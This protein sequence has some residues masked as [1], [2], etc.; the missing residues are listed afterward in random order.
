MQTI[1][2]ILD[3]LGIDSVDEMEINE[4]HTVDGGAGFMDLTIEKVGECRLLV[5]HYYEQN[6]DIMADPEIRFR[7]EDSEWIPYEYRHDPY[8]HQLDYDGEVDVRSFIT[9][10]N[11]NLENQGFVKRAEAGLTDA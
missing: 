5:A 8:T 6:R 2:R 4:R 9:Q 7:V 1:K 3:Q 10:W 11:K